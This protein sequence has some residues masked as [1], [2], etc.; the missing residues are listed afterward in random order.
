[1]KLLLGAATLNLSLAHMEN[2]YFVGGNKIKQNKNPEIIMKLLLALSS[3]V[4][5]LILL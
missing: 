5:L 4:E 3:P 1:M 2:C